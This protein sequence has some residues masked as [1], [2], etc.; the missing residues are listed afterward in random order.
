MTASQ[1]PTPARF[2]ARQCYDQLEQALVPIHEA[3]QDLKQDWNPPPPAFWKRLETYLV[4]MQQAVTACIDVASTAS[5]AHR[6]CLHSVIGCIDELG[7]RLAPYRDKPSSAQQQQ[8]QLILHALR[9]VH[10]EGQRTLADGRAW[11]DQVQQEQRSLAVRTSKKDAPSARK[12]SLFNER[13]LPHAGNRAN[14]RRHVR[15]VRRQEPEANMPD[16]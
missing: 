15:Q 5:I 3:L 14:V 9:E 11:L 12:T 7:T 1:N 4:Q 13:R 8:R 10:A 2:L 6:S 16:T